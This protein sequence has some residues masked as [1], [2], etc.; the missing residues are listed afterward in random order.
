MPDHVRTRGTIA[1]GGGTIT[2]ARTGTVT[3]TGAGA[4]TAG[5]ATGTGAGAGATIAVISGTAVA[6]AVVVPRIFVAGSTIGVV[7][8][9]NAPEVLG[10][11]HFH[12]VSRREHLHLIPVRQ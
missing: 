5:T 9:G 3:S 4:F 8:A 1:R 6:V 7:T 10:M 2:A 11:R 12:R